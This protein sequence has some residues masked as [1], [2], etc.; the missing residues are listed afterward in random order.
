MAE[1]AR[2]RFGA[3][4]GIGITGVTGPSEIEGKPVG[5][6][7][8]GISDGEITKSVLTS[9]PQHRQRIKRY[10]AMRALYELKY[11]LSDKSS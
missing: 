8:I 4:I 11:L 5:T 9:F 1:A 7:Y 2:N 6:V 3:N 10:A